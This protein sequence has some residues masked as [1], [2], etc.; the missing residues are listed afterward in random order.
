MIYQIEK[1]SLRALAPILAPDIIS[2]AEESDEVRVFAIEENERTVG[3]AAVDMSFPARAQ[4]LWFYVT[5][6]YRG[7]GI[8]R[9]SFSGLLSE[10]R[11]DGAA[12][13]S[14]ELYADTDR[15]LTGFLRSYP[16]SYEPMTVCSVSFPAEEV[17]KAK[18]LL[19]PSVNSVSL[20]T[21]SKEMREDLQKRLADEA[22]D[23]MDVRAEGYNTT[24][25]TVFQKDGEA[26]GVLLFKRKNA[27][28]VTLCF[29]ATVSDD[30][31]AFTDM[32]HYA[33]G[34]IR[35]L[36][37]GTMV[38]MNILDQKLKDF[39]LTLMKDADRVEIRE[40]RLAV[41]PLSC[42]DGLRQETQEMAELI[43]ELYAE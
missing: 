5:D 26:L 18:E 40:G 6:D 4:L 21:V 2:M 30:A 29:A 38:D 25:S 33:A 23:I 31:A 36:P 1:R 15:G 7:Y 20:R 17:N 35:Q 3:C 39:L 28:T 43:G 27:G 32:L 9:E 16:V 14:V 11:A 34:M 41:L 12:E 24:L 8:G 10:L 13:L 19:K 42:V 22:K 37:A